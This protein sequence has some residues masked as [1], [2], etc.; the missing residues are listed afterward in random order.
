MLKD[1]ENMPQMPGVPV[2]EWQAA[3]EAT[4]RKYAEVALTEA[5]EKAI[6]T[7]DGVDIV[8]PNSIIKWLRTNDDVRSRV[9]GTEYR[10]ILNEYRYL[11]AAV[12]H[13]MGHLLTGLAG[14]TFGGV[15]GATASVVGFEMLSRG[16]MTEPGRRA[17][18]AW[19]SNQTQGNLRSLI[20][21]S[22]FER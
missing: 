19:A 2:K 11:S 8:D 15:G 13:N 9:S 17:I 16:M 10:K 22:C 14:A 4:K 21:E 5:T 6:R 18:H 20:W 7:K 3:R 1:V 12:G